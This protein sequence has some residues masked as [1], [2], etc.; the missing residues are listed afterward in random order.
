MSAFFL[1]IPS[2]TMV[3]TQFF[4]AVEALSDRLGTGA[5][6]VARR[7]DLVVGIFVMIQ[8]VSTSKCGT[9]CSGGFSTLFNS[10]SG[11]G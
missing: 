4:E 9:L 7:P 6:S 5:G 8:N 1:F 10:K 11:Y 3:H 2:A